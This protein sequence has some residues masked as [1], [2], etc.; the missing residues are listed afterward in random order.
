MTL[1]RF[2][3]KEADCEENV[4]ASTED[5]MDHDDGIYRKYFQVRVV[6]V[7]VYLTIT[8]N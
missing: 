7:V 3:D 5:K 6:L 8:L 1:K 4:Y 2:K